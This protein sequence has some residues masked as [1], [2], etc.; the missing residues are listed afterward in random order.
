MQCIKRKVGDLH[1]M[2]PATPARK[3]ITSCAENRTVIV[4]TKVSHVSSTRPERAEALSP[5][6]RPGY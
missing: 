4:Y 6:Q 5:G 1:F 2:K 3:D